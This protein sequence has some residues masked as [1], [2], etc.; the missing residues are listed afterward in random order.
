MRTFITLCLARSLQH[1]TMI[2]CPKLQNCSSDLDDLGRTLI[3]GNIQKGLSEK[4]IWSAAP[5]V[6]HQSPYSNGLKSWGCNPFQSISYVYPWFLASS[7]GQNTF[8][9]PK[10]AKSKIINKKQVSEER[11]GK[12]NQQ[13]NRVSQ[14]ICTHAEI[15][16]IT[17]ISKC[18][19]YMFKVLFQVL[20]ST[21]QFLLFYI[22]Q[23]FCQNQP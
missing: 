8:M 5:V 2:H 14:I 7:V 4:R 17:T 16:I 6:Y 11:Q 13:R 22:F 3:L 15:R 23:R 20:S 10:P 18:T 12:K 1:W 9:M 21:L 19:R